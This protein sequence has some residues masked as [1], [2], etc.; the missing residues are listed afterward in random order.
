VAVYVDPAVYPLGRMRMCHM[1]ADTT[2]ELKAMA[3]ALGLKPEWIQ[4]PGQP[5][6]H[7]DICLAKRKRAIR[8]GAI[9][10]TSRDLV[11]LIR[12]RRMTREVR[13]G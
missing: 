6:E 8:L 9:E 10:V 11:R 7:F 3:V 2:E 1:L 5:D 4:K 12:A 13:N